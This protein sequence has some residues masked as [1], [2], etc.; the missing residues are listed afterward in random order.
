[1][2]PDGLAQTNL[3]KKE[4]NLGCG[5]QDQLNT[6]EPTVLYVKAWEINL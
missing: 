1:M 6:N 4:M 2:N 3:I 5:A